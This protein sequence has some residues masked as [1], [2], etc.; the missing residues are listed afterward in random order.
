MWLMKWHC[1]N[2]VTCTYTVRDKANGDSVL[3]MEENEIDYD[4]VGGDE[5][6]RCKG[7]T[8]SEKV[9]RKE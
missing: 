6:T 5:F 7:V 3:L 1:K 9:C 2:G 8:A 4:G